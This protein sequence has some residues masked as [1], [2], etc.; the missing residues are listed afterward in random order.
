MHE[1]Q[2]AK[3]KQ[4]TAIFFLEVCLMELDQDKIINGVPDRILHSCPKP[5]WQR[6]CVTVK[7]CFKRTGLVSMPLKILGIVSVSYRFK[8]AGIAYP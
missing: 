7:L 6:Y 3:K 8:K 2:K 1:N 4:K 5:F